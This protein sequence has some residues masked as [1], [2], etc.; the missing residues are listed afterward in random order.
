M[1]ITSAAKKAL[2]QNDKRKKNN[3]RYKNSLKT[4]DKE[5]KKLILAGKTEEAKKI[6][7]KFYKAVDKA[8]KA[9]IIKK[10]K[11]S[12]LKSRRTKLSNIK[13]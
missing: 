1:A 9:G 6:Y 13:K 11:A 2:R 5:I 7:P 10:N 8:A 4:A 3:L 12:R